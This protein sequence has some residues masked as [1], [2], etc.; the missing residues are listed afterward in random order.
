MVVHNVLP[1]THIW[2]YFLSVFGRETVR[3]LFIPVSYGVWPHGTRAHGVLDIKRGNEL[4]AQC[5][6]ER[7][8]SWGCDLVH[9]DLPLQ[10]MVVH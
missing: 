10:E 8:K 3:L 9:N 5:S 4:G 1:S 6:V 7:R 2:V